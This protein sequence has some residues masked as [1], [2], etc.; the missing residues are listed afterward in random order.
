MDNARRLAIAVTIARRCV[1]AVGRDARPGDET[2]DGAV[3]S[4]VTAF[5]EINA[6]LLDTTREKLGRP[7]LPRTDRVD[8]LAQWAW[9]IHAAMLSG[10]SLPGAL[11]EIRREVVAE[12][13]ERGGHVADSLDDLDGQVYAV[14]AV[15]TASEL[16]VQGNWDEAGEWVRLA[17][18]SGHLPRKPVNRTRRLTVIGAAL[19]VPV[20]LVIWLI[21]RSGGDPEPP[22]LPL[23][24]TDYA[25]ACDGKAF[26]TAPAYAGAAPHNTVVL[27]AADDD[28][29]PTSEK[30]ALLDTVQTGEDVMK[31]SR[32]WRPDQTRTVQA[33]ACVD[34]VSQSEQVRACHYRDARD[35]IRTG[36]PTQV[37]MFR[38]HFT[39]TVIE[40]RTARRLHRVEVPGEKADCPQ[41]VPANTGSIHTELTA[42]QLKSAIGR[43]IDT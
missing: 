39:I 38:G 41:T 35:L 43:F 23:S 30:W 15:R 14:T 21:A 9:P 13:A 31:F 12:S 32:A 8:I 2:A 20:V 5:A 19:A 25:P 4:A 22:A 42:D 11:D 26:P 28:H 40:V 3:L 18:E 27:T 17:R 29:L 24:I 10:R 7:E 37:F 33:V 34:L 1:A 16:Q 6:A 36:L